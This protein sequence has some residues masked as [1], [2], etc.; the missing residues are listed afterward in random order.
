MRLL[1][2]GAEALLVEVATVEEATALYAAA[3]AA[4]REA[5]VVGGT[6]FYLR[7]LAEPLFDEPPLDPVLGPG[8][9][10]HVVAQPCPHR[11]AVD[12]GRSWH[13]REARR[14]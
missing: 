12:G 9:R 5:L 3:R 7:A 6:G 1:P 2:A 13:P 10:G 8:A 11:G 4:G 14:P